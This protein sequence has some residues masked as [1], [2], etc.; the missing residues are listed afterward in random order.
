MDNT[1]SMN[2]ALNGAVQDFFNTKTVPIS[3]AP[4]AEV[5]KKESNDLESMAPPSYAKRV[6][7][8]VS[9][10]VE[11]TTEKKDNYSGVIT[12]DDDIEEDA[13]SQAIEK[14]REENLA[15]EEAE[16]ARFKVTH[17]DIKATMPDVDEKIRE[18]KANELYDDIKKYREELIT[19][20]GLDYKAADEAAKNRVLNLG[21]KVNNDWLDNNPHTGVIMIKKEDEKNI[22]LTDEEHDKLEKVKAIHLV[23]VEDA[24]VKTTKI[25]QPPR[26]KDK[27]RYIRSL[28]S[29]YYS[30]PMPI[31]GDFVTFSSSPARNIMEALGVNNPNDSVVEALERKASFVYEHFVGSN[32]IL[33]YDPTDPTQEKMNAGKEI[34]HSFNE[35]CGSFPYADLDLAIYA[36]YVAS[37]PD[38]YKIELNCGYCHKGFDYIVE[39]KKMLNLDATFGVKGEN[40]TEDPILRQTYTNILGHSSD[41]EYLQALHVDSQKTTI[42]KSPKTKNIYYIQSPSL[43]R[44]REVFNFITDK[45]ENAGPIILAS[46]LREIKVYDPSQDGYIELTGDETGMMIDY[47]RTMNEID[48]RMLANEIDKRVYSINLRDNAH[49]SHCDHDNTFEPALV[50]L[51]FQLAREISEE[52]I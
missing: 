31:W 7:A 23:L 8:T 38:N 2:N 34:I 16:A 25:V 10:P 49:C 37:A 6:S 22:Q 30:I 14:E 52:V 4:K 24:E 50:D 44:A 28:S 32:N 42:M 39:P 3:D 5:V 17:E 12:D 43:S 27:L 11:D 18:Q 35:F 26:N 1:M 13:A 29:S 41:N 19:K 21:K 36:I 20:Y 40:D 51:V 45:N 33:R 48:F 47:I 46:Y 15:K 9:A